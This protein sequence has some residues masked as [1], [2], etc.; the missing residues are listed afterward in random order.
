MF[1]FMIAYYYIMYIFL[2]FLDL[3]YGKFFL[4]RT[5]FRILL[6]LNPSSRNLIH[7]I[8]KYL[9]LIIAR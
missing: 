1:K 9:D 6:L 5:K 8:F 2:I 4:A 3:C 7:T